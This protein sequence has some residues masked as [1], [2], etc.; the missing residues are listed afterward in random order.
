MFREDVEGQFPPAESFERGEAA[1]GCDLVQPGPD[2]AAFIECPD[3]APG[4]DEG[5]LHGVLG[6]VARTEQPVAMRKQLR[7]VRA[8]E[9]LEGRRVTRPGRV[10]DVDRRAHAVILPRRDEFPDRR[11]FYPR[12]HPPRRT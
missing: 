11:G 8:D 1:V 10:E 7:A 4:P 5:F 3:V 2:E 9:R 6:V 12:T